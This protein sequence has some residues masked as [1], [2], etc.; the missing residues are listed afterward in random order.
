[1]FVEISSVEQ[2]KPVALHRRL[3]DLIEVTR[4]RAVKAGEKIITQ[5][6]TVASEFYIVEEGVFEVFW[7]PPPEEYG[8]QGD[9]PARSDR[10]LGDLVK[11]ISAE[12]SFGEL[13]LLYQAPRAATVKAKTDG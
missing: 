10:E 9:R 1:M 2:V 8:V 11:T 4:R 3:K 13:A 7:A 12:G 5:G 6:D